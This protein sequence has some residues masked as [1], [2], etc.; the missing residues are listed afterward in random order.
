MDFEISEEN[1]MFREAIREF[2][3]REIAPLVDEAEATHR[4]FY[5]PDIRWRWAAA[6]EI[7]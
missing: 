4:P 7:K 6:A 2:A 5:V 1:R 3:E